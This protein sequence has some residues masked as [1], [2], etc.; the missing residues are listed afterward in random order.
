MNGSRATVIAAVA[1]VLGTIAAVAAWPA[2]VDRTAGT[3]AAAALPTMAPVVADYQTRD[4]LVSFWEKATGEN[5]RG[6]MIS[7]RMLAAQYLQRYR[8]RMDI[9]DVLRAERATERSLAAQPVGNLPGELELASIYL[10]LHRFHDAIAVTK[11]VESYDRGDPSMYPREAS[12]DMEVGDFSTAGKRLA[13]VPEKDRDDSWRVIDSRYL[14]LT[15]HLDEARRLLSV[16]SA[17]Q[18][19]NFDAPAQSRAWYFFR[20][21]EMAFEAGDNDTALDDEREALSIFP[22][23]ADAS[24]S[25][26]RFECAL[27]EWQACLKD[28]GVS[29]D[30]VP[31]PE[32]LG[33]KADAERA[34]GDVAGSLQTADLIHT[35]GQLGDAQHITDR[36]LAIY[37]SDH[38]LYPNE[39]YAIAKNELKSRDDI[40]TEDTLAWAA[41]MDD[42]W[43]E[44][45]AHIERATVF[46]TQNSLIDYHAGVIAAHFG[47]RTLAKR[48]FQRALALNPHFHPVFADDARA[49]LTS[50]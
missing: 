43:T 16:A 49:R 20:Q 17:Y 30:I 42:R 5:H 31:Y 23:Y 24:R 34:L 12:L 7:P 4:K 50:L 25:L 35:I 32:T 36:L 46:G 22:N 29:S 1:V 47:D 48:E 41:A 13:E 18:N 27:H 37:Y 8:E 28:A 38:K 26:A 19:S 14:E 10:T 9:D 2:F 39:A 33:Y 6:D 21:G 3:A 15:G 40:F 11:H 44:A 45:H